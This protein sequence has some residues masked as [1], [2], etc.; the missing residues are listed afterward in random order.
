MHGAAETGVGVSSTGRQRM[1][2]R[3]TD[4]MQ[5]YLHSLNLCPVWLQSIPVYLLLPNDQ[6][7]GSALIESGDYFEMYPG[8]LV[9]P[10]H[11]TVSFP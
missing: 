7:L 11:R 10:S 8:I 1:S 3:R 2:H 9:N 6:L 5:N 4:E